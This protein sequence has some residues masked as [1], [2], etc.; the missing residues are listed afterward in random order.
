MAYIKDTYTSDD[1]FEY[2]MSLKYSEAIEML[3]FIGKENNL[4]INTAHGFVAGMT[5]YAGIVQ[6]M[7]RQLLQAGIT[8]KLK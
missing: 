8:F 3:R 1:Y 6:R 4:N 5:I 7:N 2:V